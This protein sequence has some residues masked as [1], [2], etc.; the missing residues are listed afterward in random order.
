MG[1]SGYGSHFNQIGKLFPKIDYAMMGIGAY[2]PRWFMSPNHINIDEAIK[3]FD[4]LGARRFIPMHYG[5][6]DQADEPLSEPLKLIKA[7]SKLVNKLIVPKL[8]EVILLCNN[9][10]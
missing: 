10:D 1:D 4:D 9:R 3:A 5:T 2:S 7:E 6:F 8:G